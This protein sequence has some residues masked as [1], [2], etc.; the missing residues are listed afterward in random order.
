MR[1]TNLIE[2]LH[3]LHPPEVAAAAWIIGALLLLAGA[4]VGYARHRR[5]RITPRPPSPDEAL[6]AWEEAMRELER[7]SAL[8]RTEA[9]R[10][11]A[12]AA[13][14]VL[15]RYLERR[16]GLHAPRL[17]TEEFFDAARLPNVLPEP[18]G[19]SVGRYLALCDLMKFGR[20]I[21]ELGE[22]Q[23]LHQTALRLVMDSRPSPPVP[24]ALPS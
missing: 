6:A 14:G 18:H 24:S 1:D 11:Y 3:L 9:S 2:D 7:C 15:R 8:L 17:T 12:I 13:T 21:A 5:R 4:A 22:L 23:L 16:F 19:E 20:A 10:E